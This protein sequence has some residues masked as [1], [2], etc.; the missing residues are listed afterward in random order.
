ML[1]GFDARWAGPWSVKS[2]E[3][4][5]NHKLASAVD[6]KFLPSLR[7]V[8]AGTSN[9]KN[10]TSKA[11]VARLGANVSSFCGATCLVGLRRSLA[12]II[13]VLVSLRFRSSQ[14]G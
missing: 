4:H 7:R 11:Y 1:V 14:I 9:P 13:S 10:R 3:P 12:R 2:Q 6:L 5:S 8:R